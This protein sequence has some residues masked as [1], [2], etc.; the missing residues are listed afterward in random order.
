MSQ[1]CDRRLGTN[2]DSNLDTVVFRGPAE[3]LTTSV[4]EGGV[5]CDAGKDPKADLM[6]STALLRL[7]CIP[8]LESSSTSSAGRDFPANW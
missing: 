7:P 8:G 2:P 3:A 6:L 4:K 1:R 5:P